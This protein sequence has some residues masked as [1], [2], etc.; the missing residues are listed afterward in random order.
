MDVLVELK[1]T[2]NTTNQAARRGLH[3]AAAKGAV[4]ARYEMG[5]QLSTR[6]E[7]PFAPSP[8]TIM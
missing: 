6:V 4:A 3:P 8:T 7:V 2:G 1:E 5:M